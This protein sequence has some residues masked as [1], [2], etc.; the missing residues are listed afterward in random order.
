MLYHGDSL[1]SRLIR[2][3]DG[4]NYSHASIYDGKPAPVANTAASTGAASAAAFE[5]GVLTVANFI[6][7]RDL[8][9]SPNLVP[10]GRLSI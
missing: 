4:S 10:A 8:L 2:L 5:A 9:R 7:P 6:T 1:V 3:F